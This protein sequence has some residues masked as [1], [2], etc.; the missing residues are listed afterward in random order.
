ML[1]SPEINEEA[2]GAALL[3][4]LR[5]RGLGSMSKTELDALLLHLIEANSNRVMSNSEVALFM[6]AP[7]ARIKRLRH[8]AIL[9]FGGG[10]LNAL[11]RRRLQALVRTANFEFPTKKSPSGKPG[12]TRIVLVVEDEF[13]RSQ[14]LGY[15]KKV[16]S[17][18]DWSFNSELLKV[19]PQALVKAMM[20]LLSEEEIEKLATSLNLTTGAKLKGKLLE[21]I[22]NFASKAREN[23][24]NRLAD[25]ALTWAKD[26]A[27]DK[28]IAAIL[29]Q[30]IG[31][32]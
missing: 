30:F 24:V 29:L 12:E 25:A 27:T 1:T 9:R 2:F 28:R 15:L 31:M 4:L 22:K 21:A 23:S 11:L 10:D 6:R 5:D 19:D 20:E 26:A 3:N 7:V 17:H 8:E 16:G 32:S 18:A 14:L 13:T